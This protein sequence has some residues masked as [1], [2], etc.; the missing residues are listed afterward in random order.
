MWPSAVFKGEPLPALP[1]PSWVS[2]LAPQREQEAPAGAKPRLRSAPRS[3]RR[4]RWGLAGR[5]GGVAGTSEGGFLERAPSPGLRECAQGRRAAAATCICCGAR[6]GASG[7]ARARRTVAGE[8]GECV[9]R[10]CAGEC[11]RACAGVWVCVR[12]GG[13]GGGRCALAPRR[14]GRDCKV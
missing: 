4:P 12:A 11:V 6:R 1:P 8:G 14:S 7:G 5:S 3:L 10:G 9:C 13:G 2:P